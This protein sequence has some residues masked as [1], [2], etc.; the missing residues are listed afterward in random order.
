MDIAL[1]K[2]YLDTLLFK[3]GIDGAIEVAD[4]VKTPVNILDD[5]TQLKVE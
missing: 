4:D 5:G 3:L 1:G 2:R